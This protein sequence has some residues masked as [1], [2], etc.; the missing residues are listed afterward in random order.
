MFIDMAERFIKRFERM[1]YLIAHKQ[2]GNPSVFAEK[3]RISKSLL[4]ECL[5][6]LKLLGC[7]IAYDKSRGTY[8]YTLAG[9]FK[10]IFDKNTY[11]P[12]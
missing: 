1:D 7:P 8:Y 2:T 11:T 9:R 12:V 3:L 5:K 6:T 4:F 10:I